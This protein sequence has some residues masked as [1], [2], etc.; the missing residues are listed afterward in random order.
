MV[1]YPYKDMAFLPRERGVAGGRKFESLKSWS[2]LVSAEMREVLDL[3]D[4]SDISFLFYTGYLGK[5]L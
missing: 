1:R 4:V 2:G 3:T 5:K